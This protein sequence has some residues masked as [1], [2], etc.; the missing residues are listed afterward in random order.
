MPEIS[1]HDLAMVHDL[2]RRLGGNLL[3]QAQP[4]SLAPTLP[5]A[6]LSNPPNSSPFN[7]PTSTLS[8]QPTP[9]IPFPP[10]SHS[11]NT[12]APSNPP[13]ETTTPNTQ[14]PFPFPIQPPPSTSQV[15]LPPPVISYSGLPTMQPLPGAGL[16]GLSAASNYSRADTNQQRLANA[17]QFRVPHAPQ[18][19]RG[20]SSRPPTPSVRRAGA[21][22]PTTFNINVVLYPHPVCAA[23][24]FSTHIQ[25][26]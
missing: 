16:P 18:R 23:S 15:T 4:A 12:S 17:S 24:I 21:A 1:D 22:H 13:P 25:I 3:P 5:S 9:T 7:F 11:F 8:T 14:L 6:P 19:P 26:N 10:P 20:P 2:L